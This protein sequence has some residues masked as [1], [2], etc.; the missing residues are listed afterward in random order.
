MPPGQ[1]PDVYS[2]SLRRTPHCSG[3]GTVGPELPCSRT[4]NKSCSPPFGL[5]SSP[6]PFPLL[7]LPV[8]VSLVFIPCCS[9]KPQLFFQGLFHKLMLSPQTSLICAAV[10][11]W[12]SVP[13]LCLYTQPFIL[14]QNF[15]F[16]SQV[17]SF[18]SLKDSIFCYLMHKCLSRCNL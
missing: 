3:Y 5:K 18:C 2:G 13:S 12:V 14:T 6:S 10:F 7:I 4:H 16:S 1:S 8:T 9:L 17:Y 11:V 15:I